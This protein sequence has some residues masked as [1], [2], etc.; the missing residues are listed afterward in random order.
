M[1]KKRPVLKL[2]FFAVFGNK[3]PPRVKEEKLRGGYWVEIIRP[4]FLLLKKRIHYLEI[5]FNPLLIE[6]L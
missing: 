5:F 6:N 2:S 3:K 1:S 4:H